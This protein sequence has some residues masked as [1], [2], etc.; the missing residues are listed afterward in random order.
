[1][2]YAFQTLPQLVDMRGKLASKG[3]Y[4]P[5]T[6]SITHRVWHHSLTK[7]HLAGSDAVS[8]ADYHVNT[9]GWPGLGYTFIIE[10]KNIIQTPKGPRARIVYANDLN[11]RTYHV[12]NS[13][14]FAVGICVAGDYRYDT[15]DDATIASIAD[16]HD[17]LEKANIGKYDT[18]HNEM[19][20]YSWKACCVYDY[21]KLI[22]WKGA[23][24]PAAPTP[25][26]DTYII[27]E[28]DTFWSIAHKDGA[29]GV[30]VDDLIKA[31][32]GVDPAK[33]KIGQKIVFG[34]ASVSTPVSKPKTTNTKPSGNSYIKTFQEWLNNNYKT[35]IAE[36][37]IYGKNTKK[38]ALKALQ[39]ELNKQY[40]AGLV[41]DGIWGPKTEVSIRTVSRGAKGNITRIV[42]GMLYS[43]GYDPK[44][45]DGIFGNGC[46]YA[47]MKFQENRKLSVDGKVG[48]TTFNKIFN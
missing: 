24:I 2:A 1:M 32:P 8:F 29:G 16:L 48:K 30:T 38:A 4:S 43:F 3:S 34:K 44:G 15:M 17:A 7:K 35:G 39:T 40:R 19:P 22:K 6:K 20:G 45:F 26:P 23:P 9:L 12:G 5:R 14:Q 21:R 36:D 46:F 28:G 18:S 13:N 42:Q 11:R 47:V 10:P 41:V 33:L 27:Q 25:L 31:N 37:N